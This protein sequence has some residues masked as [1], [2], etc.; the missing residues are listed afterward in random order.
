MKS[1]NKIQKVVMTERLYR[2]PD[3]KC[4]RSDH[5]ELSLDGI[6]TY[7]TFAGSKKHVDKYSE[8]VEKDEMKE[9]FAELYDFVRN[10][11]DCGLTI[12][13]CEH[14]VRFIYNDWHEEI[15]LGWTG[16]AKENLTGKIWSFIESHR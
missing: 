13:D 14:K 7:R 9:F 15:F 3:F 2:F 10:A 4:I 1:I 6:K 11:T 16:T 8:S 12:D 5:I